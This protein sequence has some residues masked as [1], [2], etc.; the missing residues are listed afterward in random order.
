MASF[1]SFFITKKFPSRNTLRTILSGPLTG[2]SAL[3]YGV[4]FLLCAAIFTLL[5]TL[6]NRLLVTVPARGG[7][8]SE[9]VIG[10]PH[11]INPLLAT[12]DTDNRLVALVYGNFQQDMANYTVSPDGNT[13]TITMLPNLRFSDGKLFTS[14][15]VVFTVQKMQDN[16]IS[17]VSTYWEN[18]SVENPDQQTVVFTLPAPDTT[19]LSHLNFA[20]LPKHVWENISDTNFESAKQNLDPIGSGPFKISDIDYSNG[21]PNTVTLVRNGYAAGGTPL[22]R[23]LTLISY[24][25]QSDLFNALNDG[26]VDFSYS[27]APNMAADPSLDSGLQRQSI[28]TD[29]TVS[30]YDSSNDTVLGNSANALTVSE[31]IDKNAII[32]TVLNGYGTP[33]GG[34]SN[35]TAT[36]AA[37]KK[38]PGF[39]LAVENDPS[40]LLTAQTLASQL[41]SAGITVAVKAFDPGTFQKNLD[42]GTF[43]LFLAPS[44]DTS[45]PS[46]Y[47]VVV[48]LYTENQAYIFNTNTHTIAPNTIDSPMA[49]YDSVTNWYTRT[50]RLWKWFIHKT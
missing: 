46:S 16:T 41:Q 9:G 24:A 23:T 7:N 13:Y 49:E 36:S 29:T 33:A 8:L 30:L 17:N 22:L 45:I 27:L 10:A 4:F 44:S 20:V 3:V 40:M 28:P 47:S 18:I 34:L 39:S 38:V 2:L 12:T 21:I 6:N 32:A 14:D 50:D 26:D 1:P 48:P 43:S 42:A 37:I 19:F 25:N 15:D 11:F 31:I 35:T 5:I